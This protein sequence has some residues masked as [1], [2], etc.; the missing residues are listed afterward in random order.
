MDFTAGV[1]IVNGKNGSGKSNFTHVLLFFALTGETPP[2][3][4][5]KKELLNWMSKSGFTVL[6]FKYHDRLYEL[7]RNIHNSSIGLRSIDSGTPVEMKQGDANA[8][9]AEVIGM[10]TQA[11]YKTCFAPQQRLTQV[12]KMT[13][14]ERMSYFQQLFGTERAEKLRGQIKIYQDKLP[15]YPDRTA[16]MEEVEAALVRLTDAESQLIANVGVYAKSLAEHEAAAPAMNNILALPSAAARD[17][18]MALA[19]TSLD[20]AT[21]NM[22]THKA[23]NNVVD[24]ALPTCDKPDPQGA[25]KLQQ[26]KYLLTTEASVESIKVQLGAKPAA[27]VLGDMPSQDKCMSASQLVTELAPLKQLAEQGVCPTCKRDHVLERPKEEILQEYNNAV[28]IVEQERS[29]Y[30]TALT[31]YNTQRLALDQYNQQWSVLE[32]NLANAEASVAQYDQSGVREFDEELFNTQTITWA[33]YD[34][35]KAAYTY[36]ITSLSALAVE[37]GRLQGVLETEAAKPFSSE[38]DIASAQGFHKQF[39]AVRND[40]SSLQASLASTQ[41][42][43]VGTNRRKE[44]FLQEQQKRSQVINTIEKFEKARKMLHK[45]NLQKQVMSK[46]LGTL[47]QVM[48]EYLGHFGKDYSAWIDGDFDFRA[49]KPD[50]DDFRA[51]LLSGGEQMALA[52]AYMLA[53]AEVKGS[54]IPLMVLDEPT[55]GLD[56]EAIHGLIEVLKIARSYAEKGLYIIIPSHAPEM[57]AAKSQVISMEDIS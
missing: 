24:P 32:A 9:M 6:T 57:E 52:M 54:N 34:R 8:F 17:Q 28:A 25:V 15:T 46:A 10:P 5:T 55:D 11:F 21:N 22:A 27:P 48:D 51:G 1:T 40:L 36:S 13:H 41:A 7:T 37:V 44:D 12:I 45:D 29:N 50:N 53:I 26:L 42:E 49:C 18:S 30:N 33:E 31:A 20:V 14:G 35:L 3:S 47:N 43:L 4:G 39:T 38:T 23:A 16:D 56:D 2:R 19:R